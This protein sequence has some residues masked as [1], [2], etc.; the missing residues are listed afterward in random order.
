MNVWG[1]RKRSKLPESVS[2]LGLVWGRWF[3]MT[4]NKEEKNDIPPVG[5]FVNFVVSVFM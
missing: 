1:H 4:L 3:F 5:E 2:L